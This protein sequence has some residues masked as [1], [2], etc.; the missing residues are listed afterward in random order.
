MGCG[1][2]T[3]LHEFYHKRVINYHRNMEE[4]CQQLVIEYEKLKEP[5]LQQKQQ[6][7]TLSVIR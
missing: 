3:D 2:V 4:S 1:S 5:I 7:D 6:P